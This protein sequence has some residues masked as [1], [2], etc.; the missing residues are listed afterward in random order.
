MA[1]RKTAIALPEELLNEVDRA[2][3]DRGVSRSSY[4]TSV[5]RQVVRLR[6]DAEITRRLDELF[7]NDTV[8]AEQLHVAEALEDDWRE[9]GW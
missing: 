9:E 4:I 8:R 1:V 3:A 6:R 7:A 5:L 2:A